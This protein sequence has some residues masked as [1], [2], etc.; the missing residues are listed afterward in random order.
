LHVPLCAGLRRQHFR[1]K[2]IDSDPQLPFCYALG[3]NAALLDCV[4]ARQGFKRWW[5]KVAASAMERSVY[6]LALSLAL[7]VLF[8][9]WKPMGGVISPRMHRFGSRALAARAT[10]YL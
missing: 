5:T 7:I 1:A 3:I 8:A 2:S 9:F 10:M 4:M 6:M